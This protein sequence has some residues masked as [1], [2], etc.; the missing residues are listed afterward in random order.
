MYIQDG[1]LHREN[2]R[3]LEFIIYF[4][5]QLVIFCTTFWSVNINQ[6]YIAKTLT[7]LANHLITMKI[8]ELKYFE[9]RF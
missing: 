2:L 6:L 7:L 1:R 3:N 4:L 5:K 9:K 8:T